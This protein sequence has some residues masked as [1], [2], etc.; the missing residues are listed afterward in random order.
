MDPRWDFPLNS[1]RVVVRLRSF[2]GASLETKVRKAFDF[3]R[4]SMKADH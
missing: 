2:D 3:G 4:G 1:S